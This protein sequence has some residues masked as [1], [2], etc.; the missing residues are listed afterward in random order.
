MS[1]TEVFMEDDERDDVESKAQ[2]FTNNHQIVPG[3]HCQRHHQQLCQYEGRECYRD[4]VN[5]VSL[6][7]EEGAIHDDS[8]WK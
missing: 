2:H 4:D 7:E 6:E 1:F 5:E 8:T 3:S